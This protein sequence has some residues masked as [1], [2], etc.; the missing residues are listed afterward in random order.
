MPGTYLFFTHVIHVA[1]NGVSG[2][3]AG[4]TGKMVSGNRLGG[5]LSRICN[6]PSKKYRQVQYWSCHGAPE[7]THSS[8]VISG[9][10]YLFSRLK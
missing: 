9:S 1:E 5:F 4:I 6:P 2:T 8:G 7:G 10:D 3:N